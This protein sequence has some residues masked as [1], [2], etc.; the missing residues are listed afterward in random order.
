MIVY[1]Y[2]DGQ[3]QDHMKAAMDSVEHV[4][5]S[6]LINELYIYKDGQNQDN[7][8]AAM[9]SVEHVSYSPLINELYIKRG[10][11]RIT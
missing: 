8:K 2:K 11:T 10:R 4:S 1:I 3:N 5:Y 6:P 9:D 7:M